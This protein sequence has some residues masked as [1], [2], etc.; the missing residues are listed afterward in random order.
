MGFE[1]KD[2]VKIRGGSIEQNTK[3][4]WM[5]HATFEAK[6]ALYQ[7]YENKYEKTFIGELLEWYPDKQDQILD[8]M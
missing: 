1:I 2:S 3:P 4:K 7:K 8:L 6:K 5:R